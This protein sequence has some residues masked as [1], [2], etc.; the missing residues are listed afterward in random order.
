MLTNTFLIVHL[1]HEYQFREV[2]GTSA[3]WVN[4]EVQRT[5]LQRLFLL[6][7]LGDEIAEGAPGIADRS[8]FANTGV[9]VGYR[10]HFAVTKRDVRH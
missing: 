2:A 5:V 7:K 6:R 3:Q 10:N 1:P 4:T 9:I 8:S